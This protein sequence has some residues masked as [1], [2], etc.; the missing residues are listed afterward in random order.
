[1]AFEGLCQ[2]YWF[3]MNLRHPSVSAAGP[4]VPSEQYLLNPVKCL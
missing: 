3:C 4:V 1:M 2:G